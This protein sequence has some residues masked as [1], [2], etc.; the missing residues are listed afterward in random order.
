M[1]LRTRLDRLEALTDQPHEAD[2]LLIRTGVP[3]GDDPSGIVALALRL[4]T[5][6]QGARP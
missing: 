3:R 6:T 4:S 5:T 1:T 2:P